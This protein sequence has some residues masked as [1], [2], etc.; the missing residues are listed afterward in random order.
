MG[1]TRALGARLFAVTM[2]TA[3]VVLVT[4]SASNGAPEGADRPDQAQENRPYIVV[5]RESAGSP[6]TVARHHA[7]EYHAQ[8][9]SVYSHAIDGY[10]AEMTPAEAAQVRSDPD[11]AYVQADLVLEISAQPVPTG[12]AR[13]FADDNANLDIDGVDDQRVD[14]DV[15]VIDTG[16]A[17]HPDLNVASRA[18]CSTGVC[19]SGT[20]LDDNGHGTHVAGT[21]GAIDNDTGVVGVAPGAR[22]HSVKVCNA[23]GQCPNSAIVAGVDYV[24]ARA[25]TI[26]VVNMSLGGPGTNTSLA[27]AITRS[28]NA[29]VVYAVAAGNEGQNAAGFSPANHPDVITVSALAD[30]DGNAG[31]TGGAPSCRPQNQDDTLADFSNFGASVE[32]AA[33]GVCITSTSNT[34]GLA[35]FSGTS[36]ASPHVAGAAAVLASGANDPTTRAQ[37]LAIRQQIVSTGNSNWT[38]NSGDGVKEPLLDVHDA[39]LFPP[40]GGS[41]NPPTTVF[42]DD[43]ESAAGGWATNAGGTDTATTGQ[44]QRADPAATS[45]GVALQQGTTTSGANDLVTGAAAGTDA[46]TNDVDGGTTSVLSG[47][48]TLP[49]GGTLSLSAQYYL[50]HL[51]NA[52]SADFFRISVVTASGTT[53]VF[54]QTGAGSNRAGAWGL[55]TANLTPFAGQSVRL[56]VQAAD[57][58]TASLVEA[59]V[60]DVRITQQT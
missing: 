48:I 13:I 37:V 39:T 11:V 4:S 12:I 28:V 47:P 45:S 30:S 53:Q 10:A 38:D 5:L 24:T 36:M 31:G 2:L 8:V 41:G 7:E 57:A 27:Q 29:G 33:P 44:W 16:V 59:G 49:T 3:S 46:G 50:A 19:V 56:L 26:E 21:V 42:A 60:D 15:A 55:A 14:V 40:G 18:D 25:G 6:R 22:I 1:I 17:N 34:G 52:T 9:N 54:Q 43:F 23:A 58:G 51:T 20:G 32:V 35:T